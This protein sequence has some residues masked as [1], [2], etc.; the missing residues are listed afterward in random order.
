MAN[1]ETLLFWITEI[2]MMATL[3]LTI[4]F[5]NSYEKNK[6]VT[7]IFTIV[8]LL[9]YLYS[10]LVFFLWI[11]YYNQGL[12]STMYLKTA[13]W[14]YDFI[15]YRIIAFISWLI[16]NG[17]LLASYLYFRSLWTRNKVGVWTTKKLFTYYQNTNPRV[18]TT[19]NIQ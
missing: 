7:K 11:S 13:V 6:K 16:L 18:A 3:I 12:I 15:D 5:I 4:I 10:S 14:N 8:F 17:F 1:W 9:L 2:I 19:L